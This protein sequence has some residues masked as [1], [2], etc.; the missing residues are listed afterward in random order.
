MRI[1]ADGLKVSSQG[2]DPYFHAELAPLFKSVLFAKYL[3][4]V[5]LLA[6]G[7]ALTF[8]FYLLLIRRAKKSRSTIAFNNANTGRKTFARL[9]M[10]FILAINMFYF[11]KWSVQGNYAIYKTSNEI[12]RRLSS[13]ALIAGQGVMAATIE[14][15]LRHVQAPNWYEDKKKLFL[16][17]PI[18]HLFL[19]HY[20]GYLGWYKMHYPKVMKNSEI[21]GAYRILNRDFYLFQINV[22]DDKKAEAFRWK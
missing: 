9:V 16:N 1:L 6:L 11:I 17:Y 2:I 19:S 5:L 14:N 3:L 7:I 15:R 4:Y 8:Y 13:D 12:G 18:T 21:I 20:A 10:L 22:P